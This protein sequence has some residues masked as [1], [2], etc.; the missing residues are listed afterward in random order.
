MDTILKCLSILLVFGC[1][2]RLHSDDSPINPFLPKSFTIIQREGYIMA[3]DGRTRNAFWVYEHLTRES[4][5]KKNANRR[6]LRYRPDENIP[7]VIRASVKDYYGSGFDLGHLCPFADCR[8]KKGAADETFILSNIS[9]QIHQFNRGLWK[10]LEMR[11]RKMAYQ[12]KVL[13][14]ITMPLYLPL[15]GSVRYQTL[16]N[17]NVGVPTHF[18]KVIFAEKEKGV[19]VM[20]FILPN[21]VIPDEAVLDSFKTT[22]E[23]VERLSGIIFSRPSDYRSIEY[24]PNEDAAFLFGEYWHTGRSWL[25]IQPCMRSESDLS[26]SNCVK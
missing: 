22:L 23:K 2:V 17:N 5:E 13:H 18:S 24:K 15:D 20:A 7:L 14:V 8:G 25:R 16:G 6:D 4:F 10:K 12:Y 11:V 21:A 9:P 3:Y 26:L 1:P 19:D